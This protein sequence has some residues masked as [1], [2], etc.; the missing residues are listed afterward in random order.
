MSVALVA[1]LCVHT[2]SAQSTTNSSGMSPDRQM[3]VGI[4]TGSSVS[5]I[6]T[7]SVGAAHFVYALNPGFHVGAQ[8]GLNLFSQENTSKNFFTFAPYAKLILA[9]MKDMKPYF[10]G[11]FGIRTG[12]DKTQL[13]LQFGAGAEYF[14]SRNVGIFGHISVI[15]IGIEPSVTSIGIVAPQVGIEWFFNP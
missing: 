6:G 3:G 10:Y 11:G 9:G 2:V 12:F 14:A 13:A 7:E 5:P 15:N 8:V 1:A 4:S